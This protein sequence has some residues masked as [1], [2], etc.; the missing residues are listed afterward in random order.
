MLMLVPIAPM[1]VNHRDVATPKRL[2]P[3]V[4]IKII[5]APH[6]AAHQRTQHDRSVVVEGRTE[7]RRDRQDDM[8]IDHPRVEDLAH[9]ADT[10]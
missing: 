8:A 3:D 7:H 2:A 4:A 6:P 10:G 5:H 1:R 9:L